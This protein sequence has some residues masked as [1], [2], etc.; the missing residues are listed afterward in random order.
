M[1]TFCIFFYESYHSTSWTV[2]KLDILSV[3]KYTIKYVKRL[4]INVPVVFMALYVMVLRGATSL[5]GALEGMGPEKS[6]L[7]WA[8]KSSMLHPS[9]PLV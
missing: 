5:R 8:Q 6:R 1:T 9:K 7:F 2:E 4:T 3:W